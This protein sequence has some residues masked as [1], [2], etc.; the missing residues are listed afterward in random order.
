MESRKELKK[1][2]VELLGQLNKKKLKRAIDLLQILQSDGQLL[3][4][5]FDGTIGNQCYT[6]I[7][8]RCLKVT[9]DHPILGPY[10]Q[11]IAPNISNKIT[12]T[13]ILND[14]ILNNGTKFNPKYFQNYVLKNNNEV[15]IYSGDR[16]IYE[17]YIFWIDYHGSISD[18]YITKHDYK[19]YEDL[20]NSKYQ[21]CFM[22]DIDLVQ[23]IVP[24]KN[25]EYELEQ[26]REKREADRNYYTSGEELSAGS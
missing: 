18:L 1:Q 10:E 9:K 14:Y 4:H 12:V 11:C 20:G 2:A 23:K 3:I 25:L 7:P 13:N 15:L 26:R 22:V 24:I 6:N 17:G 16:V 21:N 19:K 8:E 5:S